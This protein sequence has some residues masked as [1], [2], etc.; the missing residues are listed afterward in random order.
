MCA[1]ALLGTLND[2][3][4]Y[5]VLLVVYV[6]LLV[7]SAFISD[8][9][10]MTRN[11]PFQGTLHAT[12]FPSRGLLCQNLDADIEASQVEPFATFMRNRRPAPRFI[13]LYWHVLN[14]ALGPVDFIR[15]CQDLVTGN[16]GGRRPEYFIPIGQLLIA[17]ATTGLGRGLFLWWLMH[18]VAVY[19]L[20]LFSTPVH[21]SDYSWTEGCDKL[22]PAQ[23]RRTCSMEH[24]Y[25]H[26]E[27]SQ[28]LF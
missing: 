27:E 4:G 7:L 17:M 22:F 26:V 18:G 2:T 8:N 1:H 28:G 12:Q 3:M 16:A 24:G 23:V 13:L 21:R 15:R 5:G 14:F 11:H 6:G 25:G 10:V 20:I 19:L 9:L